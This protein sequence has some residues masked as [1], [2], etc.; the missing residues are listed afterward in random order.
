MRLHSEEPFQRLSSETVE[1]VI[2]QKASTITSLKR[3]V[4]ETRAV[5]T[6]A[7]LD[8]LFNLRQT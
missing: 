2:C 3:S 8:A 4:N 7:A 6:R 1:T 5:L